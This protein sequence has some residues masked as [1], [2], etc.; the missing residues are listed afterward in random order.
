MAAAAARGRRLALAAADALLRGPAAA[1]AAPSGSSRFAAVSGVNACTQRHA[2]PLNLRHLY[3]APPAWAP[4]PPPTD[5]RRP[6]APAAA[7][8]A[9]AAAAAGWTRAGV[10]NGPNA[11][12]LARLL[13][14][15]VIAAWIVAGD[16][17]LA[18]PALAVSAA[19]DW[20]DGALARRL[21]LKDN[22]LGTY[23]DPLADKVLVGSVVGALG[24]TGALPA[25]LVALVLG[26]DAALVAGATALRARAL[27][28]RWP[29]AAEFFR[30]AP[31]GGEG[32]GGEDAGQR[33]PGAARAAAPPSAAAPV[34]PILSSK[35]N[36]GVQLAL[37]GA[38]LVDAWLGWPGRGAVWALGGA[39][40]ATTAWSAGAYAQM[41]ARGELLEPPPPPPPR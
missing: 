41:A 40:A 26:R 24:W 9:G 21:Q 7:A 14:G 20:A 30:I 31:P 23:L 2:A 39:A 16:F 4:P 13:S 36:T 8:G 25:P 35:V 18:A 12:S 27:G 38:A 37:V 29:G 10:L 6:A 3:S 22:V 17:H 1:A 11:I 28:W 34:Q 32:G 19:S 33:E 5:D 15:P